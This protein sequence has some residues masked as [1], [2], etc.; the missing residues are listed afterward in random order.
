[1]LSYLQLITCPYSDIHQDET[2]VTEGQL[3]DDLK[4]IYRELSGGCKFASPHE[5]EQTQLLVAIRNYLGDSDS[6]VDSMNAIFKS[7]PNR[8]TLDGGVY[9]DLPLSQ[10][11]IDRMLGRKANLQTDLDSVASYWREE[12]DQKFTADVERESLAYG[13]SRIELYRTLEAELK[14]GCDSLPS[15][16]AELCGRI[17]SV[18]KFRPNAP[19][20]LQPG[21]LLVHRLA[22]EVNRLQ[23]E[24][25]DPVAIVEK[26]FCSKQAKT[27][28]FNFITS[29]LWAGVAQ[30]ARSKK[31]RRP[32][33]NDSND[34]S[35]I[36]HYAPY[37]D[38]MVIDK[39]F[40]SL[41]TQGNID[42]PKHYDVKF[43]SARTLT[44]FNDYLDSLLNSIPLEH[45]KALKAVMP[46]LPSLSILRTE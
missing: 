41:V 2:Q 31:P 28:P 44:D 30:N 46:K 9:A 14:N 3:G 38:V 19:L 39:F 21:I 17:S 40:H 45:R 16:V 36:S 11:T 33:A 13:S 8:W 22:C 34:I 7:D 26:F 4:S 32:E 1:M 42:I 20:G 6:H 24:V 27:A 37:C 12:T 23:P 15:K 5:I 43:F 18:G 10:H 29:R 25:L 35:V